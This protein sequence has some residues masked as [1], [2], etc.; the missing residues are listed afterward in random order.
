MACKSALPIAEPSA[1]PA[2]TRRLSTSAVILAKQFIPNAA[3]RD[4][5]RI[6]PRALHLLEPFQC[7]AILERE[8]F[9]DAAC[10]FARRSR[11]CLPHFFAIPHDLCAHIACGEERRVVGI[12]DGDK[13]FRY[14]PMLSIACFERFARM[15]SLH[16]AR[17]HPSQC[18]GSHSNTPKRGQTAS[19]CGLP[20]EQDGWCNPRCIPQ[21]GAF[22]PAQGML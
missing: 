19:S 13:R 17:L 1:G 7:P 9:I 12:D 15:P 5:E 22:P 10:K 2:I 6:D 3:A 4:I 16:S 20:A 21:R 18:H 14:V 11:L 8:T